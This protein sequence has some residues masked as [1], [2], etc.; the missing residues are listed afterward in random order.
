MDTQK[1]KHTLKV[2][3]PTVLVLML[4]LTSYLLFSSYRPKAIQELREVKGFSSI[5]NDIFDIPRPRYAKSVSQDTS[6]NSKSFTFQTDRSPQEIRSFYD[7]VLLKENWRIKKEGSIDNF[8]N[9]DYRK[10]DYLLTLWASYEES[11]NLTFASVEI[12]VLE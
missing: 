2:F 11:T 6:T 4:F 12:S 5:E 10:D 1:I 3:G 9:V 7:N 8:L